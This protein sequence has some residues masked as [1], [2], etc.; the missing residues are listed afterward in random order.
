MQ[1]RC[2]LA[3]YGTFSLA[4]GVGPSFAALLLPFIFERYGYTASNPLGVR[5][6]FL[7]TGL[8]ALLGVLAFIGYRLGDTP[9][10]TQRLLGQT[11]LSDRTSTKR[12]H[13]T[14]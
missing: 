1:I 9:E 2:L 6:A 5:V 10:E 8:L 11:S 3:Y 4:V 7:F 12:T 14:F 13:R